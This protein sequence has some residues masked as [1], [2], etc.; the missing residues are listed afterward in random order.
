MCGI[1]GKLSV[2]GH[3]IK[4]SLIR[5]M[6]SVLV[7]RGPDD[8]GV[9]VTPNL[10]SD[11]QDRISVG[12]GHR[13]LSIIDLS[14]AGHQPMFNEDGSI[15]IVFN[16]EIYNFSELRKL[17]ESKG[18]KFKSN[19]DTEVIIHLYEEYGPE[20]VEYLRGMFAYAI[21]DNNKQRL[22]LARDRLGK[23]PLN[24]LVN[25]KHLI[26]A[27]EIKAILQDPE[28]KKE[29]D[30][31]AIHHYLTYGY[32]PTPQTAFKGINKLPP[33]HILTWDNGK[34][35]IKRYW[36]L[37]YAN[38]VY[39]S[40]AGYSERILELLREATKIRLVSDVPLGVL[41]SGG[42]DSS[43]VVAMMSQLMQ[44]PVKTFS[45][46]FE[47]QQYDET[48]YARIIAQK[49]NT[50]HHEF[51]VK[52]N[53]IE[54]LPKLVWH[55][56]E[57]YADSSAI[58]TYY[59]AKMTREYV[60]V[61]L[62]GDAGD[63]N[64]AGYNTYT[65]NRIA[66]YYENI[67]GFVRDTIVKGAI[68]VMYRAF[69]RYR[70]PR[71]AK[72]LA[73][74]ISESPELRHCRWMTYFDNHTKEKLYTDDFKEHVINIDS[75]DLLLKAYQISDAPDFVD[76]TLSVDV[77]T[78][79]P[80]N[81]LVKMDIATMANSLEA[82]SPFLDHKLMEFV[83]SIPSNMKLR[84]MTKKYILKKALKGIIPDEILH[85]RKMGFSIPLDIWFRT[86]LK[87][88]AYDLLLSSKLRQRGYFRTEFIRSMLDEHCQGV[89]LWHS[90]LW[91]LLMLESWHQ[92]FIDQ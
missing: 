7:H 47:E 1:C 48:R 23:K 20:S 61:A 34:I 26:F 30:L 63:E 79:L 91:N 85:R 57:P 28:V 4:E 88:M 15:V 6:T 69:N 12:L 92:M 70:F 39:L 33:A 59:V 40:E 50:E 19:T 78:Y 3:I 54:I 45:I 22:V 53:A 58:P 84:R 27:S 55:Y 31:E 68:N 87:E 62:N 74:A 18:H 77:A 32:T 52:Q 8:M 11:N 65:G 44:D 46:G 75:R 16:G 25:E 35:S 64:F 72:Y 76:A 67:P 80:D 82:R 56:N 13:R 5:Q 21:W 17:V 38:K 24:Y 86:S 90:P 51:I 9:Y 49:F 14:P 37:S 43:A 83:A 29:P 66:S 60:T 89:R 71:R 10:P 2:D 42:I 81:L 36:K 41:L 73:D